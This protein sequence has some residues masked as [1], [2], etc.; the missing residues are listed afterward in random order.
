MASPGLVQALLVPPAMSPRPHRPPPRRLLV[1]PLVAAALAACGESPGADSDASSPG[2]DAAEYR[3]D[4]A[5]SP[6]GPTGPTGPGWVRLIGGADREVATAMAPLGGGAVALHG[7]FNRALDLGPTPVTAPH[8]GNAFIAGFVADG[9][10]R[11]VRTLRVTEEGLDDFLSGNS[12]VF[13]PGPDTY[14]P[15]GIDEHGVHVPQQDKG[16]G[17]FFF[18][19]F[20]TGGNHVGRNLKN[21]QQPERP[22]DLAG[23]NPQR[24]RKFLGDEF[25]DVFPTQIQSD[26]LHRQRRHC[27]ERVWH[28][29]HRE[30]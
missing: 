21:K 13:A 25:Q 28:P 27:G 20:G 3:A 16:N 7:T 9:A 29:A 17:G 19:G 15:S 1:G 18:P 14:I 10:V 6:D 22:I 30:R 24:A 5:T 23:P 8:D 12:N 26:R 4:A 2:A 11:W